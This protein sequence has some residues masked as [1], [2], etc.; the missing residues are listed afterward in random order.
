MAWVCVEDG[1]QI[2]VESGKKG[3][4]EEGRKLL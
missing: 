1:Y 3:E 4:E 2:G